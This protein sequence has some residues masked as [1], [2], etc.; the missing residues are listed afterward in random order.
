MSTR[1]K[2]K[3][4]K[5]SSSAD[6]RQHDFK[7]AADYILSFSDND[8]P[9]LLPGIKLPSLSFT[10]TWKNENVL[11][12]SLFQKVHWKAV[13]IGGTSFEEPWP[14]FPMRFL[15]ENDESGFVTALADIIDGHLDLNHQIVLDETAERK[16][17]GFRLF[18]NSIEKR[19]LSVSV[20]FQLWIAAR[21]ATSHL[22]GG[23]SGRVLSWKHLIARKTGDRNFKS[24]RLER[25]SEL[26]KELRN[27]WNLDE[28]SPGLPSEFQ[29]APA[30]IHNLAEAIK[31]FPTFDTAT[32]RKFEKEHVREPLRRQWDKP[33]L[34][35]FDP[36]SSKTVDPVAVTIVRSLDKVLQA[37]VS[38]ATHRYKLIGDLLDATYP[39]GDSNQTSDAASSISPRPW[40]PTT[41][42]KYAELQRSEHGIR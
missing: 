39:R 25:T 8:L 14:P 12:A 31:G 35:R 21:W 24:D 10:P 16:V 29:I 5:S 30:S 2:K 4:P 15:Q 11:F 3:T 22:D 7:D 23:P 27:L 36:D 40:P 13:Q 34:G 32:A 1:A 19:N 26:V 42:R 33:T 41:I 18:R 17:S 38:Q 28:D 37:D 6:G 20:V 9:T